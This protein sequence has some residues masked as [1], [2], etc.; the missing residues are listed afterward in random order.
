MTG[1]QT[2]GAS[3]S[4]ERAGAVLVVDDFE[5]VRNLIAGALAAGG[6]EVVASASAEEAL[7]V[8]D[9]GIVLAI[10]DIEMDGRSGL[11][12][13]RALQGLRPGLPVICMSSDPTLLAEADASGAHAVLHKP[14]RLADLMTLVRQ[15]TRR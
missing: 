9:S 4:E 13:M 1:N 15:L 7:E 10:T 8:L 5:P 14:F 12:L 3:R 2:H 11:E 6:L